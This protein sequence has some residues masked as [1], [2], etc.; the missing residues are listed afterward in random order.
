[1]FLAYVLKY[2]FS[3]NVLIEKVFIENECR[4]ETNI[5]HYNQRE[6]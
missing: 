1:M 5:A 6:T 4:S 3:L 2:G